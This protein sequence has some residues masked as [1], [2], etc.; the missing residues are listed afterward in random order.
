MSKYNTKNFLD[1]AIHKFCGLKINEGPSEAVIILA[2]RACHE[3]D[4][5]TIS[6]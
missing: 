4:D 2:L 3:F 6:T 5:D 1:H